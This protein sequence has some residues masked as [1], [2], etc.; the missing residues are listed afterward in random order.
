VIA[1]TLTI[2]S[3]IAWNFAKI[4]R[5]RLLANPGR[6]PYTLGPFRKEA[7]LAQSWTPQSWQ[8]RPI[9]QVPDYPDREALD[10][11]LGRLKTHPPLVF[12]GE[13]RSLMTALG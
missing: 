2:G 13:A 9:R 11:V 6:F 4:A 12:A 5:P 7:G 10:A 8:D 1:A 3:L